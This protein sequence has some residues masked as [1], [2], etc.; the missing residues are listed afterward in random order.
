MNTATAR[1]LKVAQ[2]QIGTREN[3]P[4]SNSVKYNKAYYKSDVRAPWC[5]VFQWWC[6]QKAGLS[7]AVFPKANNVFA[8]RDWYQARGRFDRTPKPGSLVIYS[9]SHIGIVEK[10]LDGGRIQTIEGNTDA[11]GSRT[12]G[13]VMRKVRSRNILGYCHPDYALAGDPPAA[14]TDGT[15][16]SGPA[17][18]ERQL[19]ALYTSV[20][21]RHVKVPAKTYKSIQFTEGLINEGDFWREPKDGRGGFAITRGPGLFVANV[22]LDV[23]GLQPG[24]TLHYR[25]VEVDPKKNFER[26]QVHAPNE[27]RVTGEGTHRGHATTTSRLT[28]GRHLWVQVYC[29]Q[30]VEVGLI[31]AEVIFMRRSS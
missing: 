4:D 3:P 21:A 22:T 14:R 16:S 20:F 1:V 26:V 31:K 23:T 19:E 7:T 18:Q 24:T 25:L 5:V 8:V 13:K 10:V 30:A 28:A 2:E 11:L 12:G 27:L 29:L 6:F 15:A 9:F 17:R